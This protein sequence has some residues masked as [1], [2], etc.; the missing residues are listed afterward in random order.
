MCFALCQCRNYLDPS[1]V[2]KG[3]V[4]ETV[5]KVKLAVNNL[6]ALKDVYE[7]YRTKLSSYFAH[8]EPKE[9]EFAPVLVF[10][11]YDKFIERVQLVYVSFAANYFL[12]YVDVLFTFQLT[13]LVWLQEGH[14]VCKKFKFLPI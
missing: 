11:R 6:T 7:Q 9:W 4:E 12:K 14:L 5:V 2:F 13:L 3:E 1:E 8:G 10:H